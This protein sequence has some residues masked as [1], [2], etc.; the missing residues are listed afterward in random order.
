MH[1]DQALIAE[2]DGIE[3]GRG[4]Q[5]PHQASLFQLMSEGSQVLLKFLL[6]L[7]QA[8]ATPAPGVQHEQQPGQI[9]AALGQ[10][11]AGNRADVDIELCRHTSR[12]P[13]L[14]A[15]QALL[16]LLGKVVRELV[17]LAFIDPVAGHIALLSHVLGRQGTGEHRQPGRQ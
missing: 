11:T 3:A 16:G 7:R 1:F 10:L 2:V 4:P 14:G 13:S 17:Q 9:A 6:D 5:G 12:V 8:G 15:L